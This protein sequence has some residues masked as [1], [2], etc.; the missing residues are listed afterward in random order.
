MNGPN[1]TFIKI[2]KVRSLQRVLEEI[3]AEVSASKAE[4][5]VQEVIVI[6]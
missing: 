2:K 3:V 1:N 5:E 6:N 4:E